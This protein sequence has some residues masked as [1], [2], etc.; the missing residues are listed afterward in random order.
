MCSSIFEYINIQLSSA[1]CKYCKED[2]PQFSLS[3]HEYCCKQKQA[4]YVYVLKLENDK[5]YVGMTKHPDV[6]LNDHFNNRGSAW[7]KKYRPIS[8]IEVIPNCDEFDEDKYTIKYMATYGLNNV[9]GGS[10]S[11]I[12][13]SIQCTNV[14]NRMITHSQNKC[15]KCNQ[16]GHYINECPNE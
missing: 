13:L 4:I 3:V 7:T 9:R 15:F 10:F 2:F 14:I 1:Q 12:V 6:R 5:Y 11:Q 8:I 16:I